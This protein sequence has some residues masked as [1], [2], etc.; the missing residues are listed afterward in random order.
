MPIAFFIHTLY[1]NDV[2][3]IRCS[4][5]RVILLAPLFTTVQGLFLFNSPV[6]YTVPLHNYPDRTAWWQHTSI[7]CASGEYP[8][9]SLRLEISGL[10]P[11]LSSAHCHTASHVLSL[12]W[13]NASVADV[14]RNQLLFIAFINITNF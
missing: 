9:P 8:G 4:Y 14:P 5:Y 3:L 10:P 2:Y 1:Y 7:S 11:L 6:A 12:P 13:Y